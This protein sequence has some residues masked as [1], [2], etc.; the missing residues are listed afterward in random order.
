MHSDHFSEK[1]PHLGGKGKPHAVDYIV[2]P[3]L[4]RLE[5]MSQYRPS[6]QLAWFVW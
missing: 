4:E 1:N 2:W 3:W 5:P 6:K